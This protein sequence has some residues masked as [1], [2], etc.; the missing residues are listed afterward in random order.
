MIKNIRLIT[1]CLVLFA[2]LLVS[3]CIQKKFA[4]PD[5][6]MEPVK[7]Y[8]EEQVTHTEGSL[9]P[10]E[11]SRNMLFVDSKAKRLGDIVTINISENSTA[12][13]KA[14]TDTTKDSS[15]AITTG[16]LLGLPGNLGVTNFL[17]LGSPFNPSLNATNVNQF[18]GSGTTTR[19]DAFTATIA[20]IIVEVLP[21][22]NFRV[23]GKRRVSLN[24][25]DQILTLAGIIRPED[26]AFDNTIDSK[27]IANARITYSGTGVLSDKQRVGWGIK[28]LS[29]IWPF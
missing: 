19:E 28:L 27:L 21:N 13:K 23:V 6:S 2:T 25:E 1:G 3:G 16:A 22:G 9:W 8:P 29:W 17:G 20:A 24:N 7:I 12:T 26:I 14:T 11:N 4:T 15:V 5:F 10:G 18:S